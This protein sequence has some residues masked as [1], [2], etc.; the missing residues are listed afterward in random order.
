MRE[1]HSLSSLCIR[2][3]L[4]NATSKRYYHVSEANRPH[5]LDEIEEGRDGVLVGEPEADV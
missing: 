5:Q 2:Q 4:P 3:K 1:G